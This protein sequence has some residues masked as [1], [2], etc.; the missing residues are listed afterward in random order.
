VRLFDRSAR[1]V[2]LTDEGRRFYARVAPLLAGLEAAAGDA[3]GAASVVRGRLRVSV[4]QWFMKLVL[5]PRLGAFLAEHPELTLELLVRER[6][7]DLVAD[8]FDAAVRFGEPEPSALIARRL[9]AT[10]IVTCA[11]PSYLARCG[12]PTHPRELA[13]GRHACVRFID[14]ATG[15][16]FGWEFWRGGEVLEVKVPGRLVLNDV[17]SA[18]AVAASGGGIIQAMALG[19]D[20]YLRDGVLEEV[21]PDW[22]EERFPLY[23]YHPSR[24]LPP[25]KVRAFLTFVLAAAR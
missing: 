5:A 21:F 17:A 16:P 25:A 4:D 20:A 3:S 8:G 10:R 15:R 2:A 7:G 9:L 19:L 18:L 13:N 1:A 23:A 6:L 12:R 11:A 14:P 24:H 22:G